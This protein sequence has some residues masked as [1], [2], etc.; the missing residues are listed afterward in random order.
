MRLR[1][2]PH[3]LV[4]PTIQDGEPGCLILE[5]RETIRSCGSHTSTVSPAS[6]AICFSEPYLTQESIAAESP[7]PKSTST[8]ATTSPKPPILT[9]TFTNTHTPTNTN[10]PTSPNPSPAMPTT[11][12]TVALSP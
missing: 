4:S 5:L 12:R 10:T 11:T 2:N 8:K 3:E 1:L 6:V 7:P 9:K